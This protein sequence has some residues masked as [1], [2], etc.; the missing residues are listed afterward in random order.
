MGTTIEAF[1]IEGGARSHTTAKLEPG[2]RYYIIA[3]I[4]WSRFLDRG[5]SPRAFLVEIASP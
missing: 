1:T 2:G 4:R 3:T 5:L